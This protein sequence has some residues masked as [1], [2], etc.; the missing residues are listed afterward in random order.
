[1]MLSEF[2]TFTG[3]LA[4]EIDHEQGVR[5]HSARDAVFLLTRFSEWHPPR[6]RTYDPV[7]ATQNINDNVLKW[8]IRRNIAIEHVTEESSGLQ[9]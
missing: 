9:G 4:V 5:E 2:V 8:N 7:C 1:M 6:I 3:I